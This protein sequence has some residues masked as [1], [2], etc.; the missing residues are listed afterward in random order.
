VVNPVAHGSGVPPEYLAGML[1]VFVGFTGLAL[2]TGSL[3]F[4]RRDL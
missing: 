2:I 3:L 1:G 4:G